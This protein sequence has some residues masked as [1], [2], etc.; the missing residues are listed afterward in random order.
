M[1]PE[2]KSK[3]PAMSRPA[4]IPVSLLSVER[5]CWQRTS[6]LA[7]A[8]GNKGTNKGQTVFFFPPNLDDTQKSICTML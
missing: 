4:M 8:M 7:I 6:E 1:K 3:H 5:L 2:I